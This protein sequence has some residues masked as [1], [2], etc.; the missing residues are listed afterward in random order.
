MPVEVG[1]TK[2]MT[3]KIQKTLK[4]IRTC[5]KTAKICDKSCILSMANKHFSVTHY[6]TLTEIFC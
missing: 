1:E 6:Q 3:K 5:K 4:K 2:K